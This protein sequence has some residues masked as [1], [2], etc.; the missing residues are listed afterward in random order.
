MSIFDL[1]KSN[2]RY[3]NSNTRSL[4]DVSKKISL[5]VTGL[6]E[7]DIYF[8]EVNVHIFPNAESLALRHLIHECK[9]QNRYS[10][11]EEAYVDI[12]PDE[13][14]VKKILKF[15]RDLRAKNIKIPEYYIEEYEKIAKTYAHLE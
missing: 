7:E 2:N 10:E 3:D 5:D 1:F 14:V 8:D 12:P 6:S 13:Q 11:K 15:Y 9:P 4:F